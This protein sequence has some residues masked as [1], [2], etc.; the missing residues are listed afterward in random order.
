MTHM[1]S[2]RWNQTPPLLAVRAALRMGLEP[3]EANVAGTDFF[4]CGGGGSDGL[5]PFVVQE[6]PSLKAGGG[7]QG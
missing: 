7:G 3:P 6:E 2:E 5:N 4:T 1:D